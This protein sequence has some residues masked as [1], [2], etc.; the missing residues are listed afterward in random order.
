MKIWMTGAAAGVMALAANA[1]WAQ[2]ETQQTNTATE[3]GEIVVTGQAKTYAA[4]SVSQEMIHRQAPMASVNEVVNELPGVHVTEADFFGSADFHTAITMRGF[5]SGMG[6]QQIGTTIDGLPNGGSS[7]GGGSR[8]N[9]YFDMEDLG[10]VEVSQ[11]TADIGS[12]SNE[13][14]GGTLN[15]LSSDPLKDQRIRLSAA[16][17]DQSAKRFYGRFDTGE[18]LPDTFAFVSASSSRHNDWVDDATPT[19][20]DHATAKVV[21]KQGGFDL[22]GF[23]SWD[24]VNEAEYDSQSLAA[25]NNNPRRDPLLPGW[26]GIPYFDQR[27]RDVSRAHRENIFTYLRGERRFGE[28]KVQATGYYHSMRGQGDFA[29]PYIINLVADGAGA[30]ESE[31]TPGKVFLRRIV[32]D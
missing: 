31:L 21:S 30:P 25:F 15:F 32:P 1:A 28:V 14:L 8:A 11:G 17:G 20:R 7:Y 10:T 9:R 5:N 18:F 3:V 29:P 2:S 16:I 22:T 27:A 19:T 4:V 26:T 23:L 12:R 24:K 13:A 6:A